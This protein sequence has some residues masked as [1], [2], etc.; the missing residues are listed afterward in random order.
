[1]LSF[2]KWRK[3]TTKKTNTCSV[4]KYTC[5]FGPKRKGFNC[6]ALLRVKKYFNGRVD[7]ERGGKDCDHTPTG[8][9]RKYRLY[10]TDTQELIRDAIKT[11]VQAKHIRNKLKESGAVGEEVDTLKGRRSIYQKTAR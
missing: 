2:R 3:D 8:E 7:V 10:S 4:L 6:R 1:M 11:N 5:E 9:E